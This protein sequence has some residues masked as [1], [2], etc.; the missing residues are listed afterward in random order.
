M[1]KLAECRLRMEIAF[2][3][4]DDVLALHDELIQRYKETP[5]LRDAGLLGKALAMSQAGFGGRY[6]HEFSHEMGAAYLFHPI[7]NH[8]FIDG[9]KRI[10]L[11]CAGL[12]FKINRVS[13]LS[14]CPVPP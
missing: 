5:G 12:F 1:Q 7:R 14:T 13:G 3:T 4:L 10:A 8:A 11:A 6:F 9:N 2:L